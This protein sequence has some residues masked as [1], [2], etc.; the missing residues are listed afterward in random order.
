MQTLVNSL[1][2]NGGNLGVYTTETSDGNKITTEQVAVA[3]AKGWTVYL[4]DSGLAVYQGVLLGDA[5]SDSEV[6][7]ADI[8]AIVSHMK[9]SDV[10]GFSLPAAD[11]NNDNNADKQD[12][13]LIKQMIMGK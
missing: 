4:W 5:N 2:K 6:N 13:E 12:I 3:N 1:H 11:V 10:E 7:V 8:V 9:G